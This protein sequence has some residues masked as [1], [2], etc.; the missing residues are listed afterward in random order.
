[1]KSKDFMQYRKNFIEKCF[2]LSD[3]KRIEYTENNQELDVHTNFRRI[4]NELSI[5]PVKVI[6]V[7]LF[8]HVKSLITF[9][10]M[11]KTFSNETLESRAMDIINYLI[12]LMSYLH[13]EETK[14]QDSDVP[15]D[16][17]FL[18]NELQLNQEQTEA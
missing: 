12:L 6:G 14:V 7:Y 9:F 10:K 16:R 4:G 11:G 5:N 13:Y 18:E 8:K 1:M 3:T 2:N 15:E 17:L